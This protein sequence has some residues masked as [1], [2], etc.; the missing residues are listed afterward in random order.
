MQCL[1]KPSGPGAITTNTRCG[2]GGRP[3][4]GTG[5][6]LH[7]ECQNEPRAAVA[8]AAAA[9]QFTHKL[10]QTTVLYTS[11]AQRQHY[12]TNSSSASCFTADWSR[13]VLHTPDTL[14]MLLQVQHSTG[15]RTTPHANSTLQQDDD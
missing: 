6:V 13:T 15:Q 11:M 1:P 5:P 8:A 9:T 12:S 2:P 7:V 14:C 3:G 4:G 10:W